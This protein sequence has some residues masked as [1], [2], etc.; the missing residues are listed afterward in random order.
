[1]AAARGELRSGICTHKPARGDSARAFPSP[2]NYLKK[3]KGPDPFVMTQRSRLIS[4]DRN[5]RPGPG[6]WTLTESDRRSDHRQGS[7]T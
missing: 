4:R 6:N 5:E 1:M 2:L 7:A 3:R